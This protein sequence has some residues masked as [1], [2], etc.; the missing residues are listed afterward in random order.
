MMNMKHTPKR[1]PK[2]RSDLFEGLVEIWS[3]R[4]QNDGT[5]ILFDYQR[6]KNIVLYQGNAEIIRT[7]SS[8]SPTKPRVITRMCIGDQGTIPSDSTVPK[9]PIKTATSLY[10][11]IYRKD[12]DSRTPTL[13]SPIGFVYT[14][15]TAIGLNIISG[16]SSVVGVVLGMT[17]SGTGIPPG[18]VVAEIISS[19]SIKISDI[20]TS[21]NTGINITFAGVVNECQ[22]SATFDAV[23]VPLTS[24]ANPS[25]P[26]LNEVGLV[27]IDPTAA[28]GLV[29]APV[30]GPNA[31]DADE[32]LM[33]IRTFKSVPFEIANDVSVT[34]RYTIFTE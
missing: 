14:G 30:A 26:R 21:T 24:F 7:L 13:Y 8:N 9:V 33:T 20:A 29:R 22:F 15:N 6:V 27:L 23:D 5:K 19:T 12:I 2:D 4:K 17:V 3:Y 25:Q 31:S 32:V 16:L 28:G 34:I 1:G 10:H 11:E 18:A